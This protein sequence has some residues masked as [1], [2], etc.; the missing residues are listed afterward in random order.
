[1]RGR[2]DRYDWPGVLTELA[3]NTDGGNQTSESIFELQHMQGLATNFAS[4]TEAEIK[5]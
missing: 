1:M 3:G 4:W 2:V 5:V